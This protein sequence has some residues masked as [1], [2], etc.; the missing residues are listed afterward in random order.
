LAAILSGF[1]AHWTVSITSEPG[2]NHQRS[3]GSTIVHLLVGL[4][5]DVSVWR[6]PWPRI[7][8]NA[9]EA[10]KQANA[11]LIFFDN[12]YVREGQRTY[13]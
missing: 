1:K 12:V 10:C 8:G 5:Y 3:F 7:M 6:E 4:K 13:D 9:I 11:K 2:S